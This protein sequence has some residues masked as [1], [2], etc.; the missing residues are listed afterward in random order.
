M[1]SNACFKGAQTEKAAHSFHV[2]T[3]VS[4]SENY[5]REI[6]AFLDWILDTAINLDF[7]LRSNAKQRQRSGANDA[8]THREIAIGANAHRRISTYYSLT[9]EMAL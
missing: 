1:N 6:I 5:S 8:K 3:P 9:T 2:S 7:A 4:V